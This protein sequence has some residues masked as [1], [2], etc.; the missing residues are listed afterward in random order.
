[1]PLTSNKGPKK[2][3]LLCLRVTSLFVHKTI[4]SFSPNER[5]HCHTLKTIQQVDEEV[6][7]IFRV[8]SEV[9]IGLN[10]TPENDD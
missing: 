1:M 8:Y 7:M 6:S 3:L 10:E 5:I 2:L 9:G 4:L